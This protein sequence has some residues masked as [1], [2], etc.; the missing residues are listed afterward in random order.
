MCLTSPFQLSRIGMLQSFFI[1]QVFDAHRK[2]LNNIRI[3]M[4][5][6]QNKTMTL[7][8]LVHFTYSFPFVATY[9][10]ILEFS[11]T[12]IFLHFSAQLNTLWSAFKENLLISISRRVDIQPLS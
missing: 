12:F 2:H 3:T 10:W 11:L 6:F 8:L 9:A 4:N 1:K 7:G 5:Y